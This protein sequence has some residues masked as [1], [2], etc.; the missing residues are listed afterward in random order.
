MLHFRGSD[1]RR[2]LGSTWY[3]SIDSF[4]TSFGFTKIKVDSNLYYKVEEGNPVI[5]LLYVDDVFIK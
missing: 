1:Y 2:F 5:H 4:L 3:N